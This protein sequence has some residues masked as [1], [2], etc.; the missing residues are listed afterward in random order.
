MQEYKVVA[1]AVGAGGSSNKVYKAGDIVSDAS[2]KGD[3]VAETLVEKGFLVKITKKQSEEMSGANDS[4]EAKAKEE[5][6]ESVAKSKKGKGRNK[7]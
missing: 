3:Q 7:K 5:N 1:L 4:F 2:F 6:E